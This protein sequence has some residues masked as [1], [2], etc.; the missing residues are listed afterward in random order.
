MKETTTPSSIATTSQAAVSGPSANGAE[1]MPGSPR[2]VM[3]LRSWGTLL[4]GLVLLA[5]LFAVQAFW[6]DF[7]ARTG[8]RVD[9]RRSVLRHPL[10]DSRAAMTAL[11][12]TLGLA[13]AR[14]N[15][16]LGLRPYLSF[17]NIMPRRE[18]GAPKYVVILRNEG[19]GPAVI[20]QVRYRLKFGGREYE[21]EKHETIVNMIKDQ[22]GLTEGSDYKLDRFSPGATIGKDKERIMFEVKNEAIDRLL[23]LR[24]FDIR[25]RYQ[26]MLG[27]LYEKTVECLRD[28]DYRRPRTLQP[29]QGSS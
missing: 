5:F 1:G 17:S 3:Q 7:L 22:F 11:I 12:G 28:D 10:L 26:G 16:A 23:S 4:W 25:V 21:S 6:A 27:D 14:H 2:K 15:L 8:V 24:Q 19:T 9:Q 29:W 13:I 18:D 20:A